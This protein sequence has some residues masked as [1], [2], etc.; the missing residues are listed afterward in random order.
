MMKRAGKK[1]SHNSEFQLWQQDNHPIELFD[2]KAEGAE[3]MS[4]YHYAGDNPIMNNDPMGNLARVKINQPNPQGGE[5]DP[6]LDDGMGSFGDQMF[7]WSIYNSSDFNSFLGGSS[8]SGAGG[9]LN[10]SLEQTN[11]TAA[12]ASSSR[13]G[14][15]FATIFINPG[16]TV[17]NVQ[18]GSNAVFMVLPGGGLQYITDGTMGLDIIQSTV[19]NFLA[20]NYNGLTGIVSPIVNVSST[21]ATANQGGLSNAGTAT[22][23]AGGL[24]GAA[25]RLV[26]NGDQWLGK[27]GKYYSTD[28]GGNGYTGSRAGALEAAGM[29]KWA[30]RATVAASVVIGG[31]QVYGGYQQDGGQFGYHAQ[32]AAAGATGGIIGGWAGAEGGAAAGAAI[33]VWFGGVGA[34]PGAVIGGFIGGYFGSQAGTAIGSGAVNYYYD[35][36]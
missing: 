22:D 6:A 7:L 9:D 36:K 3:S 2:L 8:S 18:D 20:G 31:L 15:G 27:N 24:Y 33:G 35:N 13:S 29:Y 30:G 21:K 14:L 11:I 16:G 28:W 12:N 5:G 34:L 32:D 10:A 25:G 4:D 19:D 23:I 17:T 26:L 1:N